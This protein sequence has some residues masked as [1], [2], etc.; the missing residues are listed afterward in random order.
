MARP[1]AK[2]EIGVTLLSD[3]AGVQALFG[4]RVLITGAGGSIGSALVKA[5]ASQ[6]SRDVVLLDHSERNL[7]ELMTNVVATFDGRHFSPVL[8]S[9]CDVDLLQDLFDRHLPE[10]VIHAAA[11]KHVPLLESTPLEAVLNNA[12][13]TYRL[14]KISRQHAVSN[15]LM[16]STDK[17]VNPISIM[18][19]SKRLAEMALVHLGSGKTRMAA[20]RLGNVLGTEGS[21][22][23]LFLSQISQGGPVTVTDPRATRYFFTMD[24]A[25]EL[26]LST[27]MQRDG[28]VFAPRVAGPANVHQMAEQ[29]INDAKISHPHKIEILFTGLRPGDKLSEEFLYW[30]EGAQST[31]DPRLLHIVSSDGERMDFER[32]MDRLLSKV[33]ER[34]ISGTIEVMRDLVPEYRPSETLARLQQ[35]LTA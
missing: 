12:I 11:F 5:V 9:I 8:G 6:G 13:G 20:I 1:G 34:D 30:N 27:L 24:Q 2:I 7:N 10:I 23:P 18:G 28:G 4:K 29:L 15:L 25:V 17:A 32:D 31:S 35:E 22:L 21:V 26:I 3:H 33:Y 19:A 14:A 16:L